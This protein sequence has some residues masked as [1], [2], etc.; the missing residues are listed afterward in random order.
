LI[1]VAFTSRVKNYKGY[2]ALTTP[3]PIPKEIYCEK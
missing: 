1:Y 2:R 3:H